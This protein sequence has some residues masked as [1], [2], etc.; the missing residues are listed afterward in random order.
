MAQSTPGGTSADDFDDLLGNDEPQA[1]EAAA[2]PDIETFDDLL[3]Q[4]DVASSDSDGEP[5]LTP[6]QKRIK[7]LEAALAEL[8]RKDASVAELTPEQLRIIEL[9]NQLAD[10]QASVS[11]LQYAPTPDGSEKILF[12]FRKDGLILFGNVWMRGQE[13]EVVVGSHEHKRIERVLEILDDEDA[14]MAKWGDRYIARGPFRP[15]KG[16]KFD[17]DVAREDQRRGRRVPVRTR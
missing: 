8:D 11:E 6:E 3:A 16:E 13:I 7:E 1:P 9:E 10:R 5:E 2:G 4:D 17:D 12:H 15:R 14:Q